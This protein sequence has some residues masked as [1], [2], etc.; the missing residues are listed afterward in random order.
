MARRATILLVG[1]L[2]AIATCPAVATS[3]TFQPSSVDNQQTQNGDVTA[4]L[5]LTLCLA[6]GLD[7]H[8]GVAVRLHVEGDGDAGIKRHFERLPLS[9]DAGGLR[10]DALAPSGVLVLTACTPIRPPAPGRLSTM[11]FP[12]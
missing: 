2:L 5:D 8:V 11:K 10:V 7:A 6:V 1:T 4:G 9:R 3:Q 12:A